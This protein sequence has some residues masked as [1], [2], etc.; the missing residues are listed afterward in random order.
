M[1]NKS[2]AQDPA[3]AA[4]SAIEEALNLEISAPVSARSGAEISRLRASSIADRAAF[5]GS[6]AFDLFAITCLTLLVR[7]RQDHL[8]PKRS[9]S[10]TAR[11][12][13][14]EA[15]RDDSR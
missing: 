3:N 8:R 14:A 10:F 4:L 1:A 2:K 6:C 13:S 11:I 7:S 9:D 12:A 5:A 15:T